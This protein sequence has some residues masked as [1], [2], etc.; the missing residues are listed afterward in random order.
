MRGP[1]VSLMLLAACAT[2]TP[3]ERAAKEVKAGLAALDDGRVCRA[4]GRFQAAVKEDEDD[5]DALRHLVQAARECG[6]LDAMTRA[7]QRRAD[8]APSSA[9]ARYVLGLCLLAGS[10]SERRGLEELATAH[11]LEPANAEYALRLGLALLESER[12]VEAVGPLREAVAH[13]GDDPHAHFP[14]AVALHRTGHDEDAIAEIGAALAFEPSR[15]DIQEAHKLL[16]LIHDPYR[17][18][19][20]GARGQFREGLGW[21][22]R[23]EAPQRAVD[24]FEILQQQYPQVAAIQSVLGLAYQRIGDSSQAVEH[25]ERAAQ[26]DPTLPEP[27][28]Y[29]GELY[30]SLRHYEDAAVQYRAAIAQDPLLAAARERLAQLLSENGDLPGAAQQLRAIV[31]LHGGDADS[32]LALAGTLF[33][34]GDLHG[35]ETQLRK[36]IERAGTNLQATLTL[37]AEVAKEAEATHDPVERRRLNDQARQLA[38][39]VLALQPDNA[40]ASRLVAT[41]DGS[42]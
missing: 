4:Y 9:R 18:L 21:L 29:L 32:R 14:L 6:R 13:E 15:H 12:F 2:G 30:Y 16:E 5:L 28:L 35:A 25:F 20:Q 33:L 23:E 19:P 41:I 22:E 38:G 27:H 1:L 11:R 39:E 26:L 17:V 10:H 3:A 8:E 24:V 36:V 34:G 40:V 31:A 37:A 7:A 42:K